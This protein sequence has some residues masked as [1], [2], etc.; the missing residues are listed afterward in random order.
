M[1]FGARDR[2]RPR[3]CVNIGKRA[4]VLLVLESRNGVVWSNHKIRLFPQLNRE[5]GIQG[6]GFDGSYVGDL[7]RGRLSNAA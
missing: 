3:N 4:S 5:I 6:E 7:R 2:G 1:P